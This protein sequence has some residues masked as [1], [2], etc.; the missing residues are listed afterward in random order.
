[1]QNFQTGFNKMIE[2]FQ[3]QWERSSSFRA[4]WSTIGSIGIILF[5][6]I[7]I[8][9]L[10]RLGN[11]VLQGQSTG[12]STGSVVINN[13]VAVNPT[14]A[15]PPYASFP[16]VNTAS[17]NPVATAVGPSPTPTIPP[18]PLGATPT[19]TMMPTPTI[20]LTPVTSTPGTLAITALQSPNPWTKNSTNTIILTVVPT[21][22]NA[23]ASIALDF[24][25]SCQTTLP[26]ATISSATTNI[27]VKLPGCTNQLSAGTH[28]VNATITIGSNTSNAT[29]TLNT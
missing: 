24:G 9:T 17:A 8:T 26:D 10:T 29:F 11:A 23:I 1:M 21:Q 19:P 5:M 25:N 22:Q 7:M 4:T 14:Y 12:T 15:V 16:P 13:N 20:S 3:D 6:G 18:T 2:Q 28:T 27:S